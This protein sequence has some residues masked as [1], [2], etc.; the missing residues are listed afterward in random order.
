MP[1]TAG[2]WKPL[3][4]DAPRVNFYGLVHERT[5]ILWAQNVEHNWK[6]IFEKKEIAAVPSQEIT[7]RS[8]PPGRYAVEWFDTWK[9]EATKR[10]TAE[11]KDGKLPLRLPEL[12]TDVAA[13]ITP[14]P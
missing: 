7:V 11:C 2:E 14:E 4:A 13:R 1:W 3:E 8:L 10:E 12:T 9:G 6:N 5:A